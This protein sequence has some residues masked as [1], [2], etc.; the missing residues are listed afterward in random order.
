MLS[1][2]H[3]KDLLEVGTLPKPRTWWMGTSLTSWGKSD[4]STGMI[5]RQKSVDQTHLT[6]EGIDCLPILENR[7]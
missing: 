7:R 5:P 6:L 1:I 2:P 3:L 4:V